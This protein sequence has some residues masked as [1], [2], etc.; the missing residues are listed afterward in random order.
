M[1]TNK[2]TIEK[3]FRGEQE[4]KF[5]MRN[6]IGLKVREHDIILEDG[7][8]A[9]V[10]DKYL[11]MLAKPELDNGTETWETG[12]QVEVAVT[13]KGGYFN[14]RVVGF[15]VE[16]RLKKLEEAVFGAKV[17]TESSDDI[18]PDDIDI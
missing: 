16:D 4:T 8:P 2:V 13:E 1:N 15:S 5:G 12:Q 18:N 9:N 14:F 7:S 10:D 6:K 11:T 3:I 17:V